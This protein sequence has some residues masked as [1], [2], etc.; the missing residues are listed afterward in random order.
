MSTQNVILTDAWLKVAEAADEQACFQSLGDV[1][2]VEYATTEDDS[3]PEPGLSG[4]RL[5]GNEVMTRLVIG[6]GYIWAR[7]FDTRKPTLLVVSGSS[8]DFSAT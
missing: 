3:D 4:H 6:A 7:L 8:V 2:R 1:P 5:A